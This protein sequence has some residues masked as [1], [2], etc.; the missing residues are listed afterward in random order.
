MGFCLAFAFTHFLFAIP[1]LFALS[2]VL[3]IAPGNIMLSGRY[4]ALMA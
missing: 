1:H 4:P 3:T 2:L